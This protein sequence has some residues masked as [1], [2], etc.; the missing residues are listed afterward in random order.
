M[1]DDKT[2]WKELDS[3]LNSKEVGSYRY[4]RAGRA[5]W[6]WACVASENLISH[7]MAWTETRAI[8][9]AQRAPRQYR[10]EIARAIMLERRARNATIAAWDR[11]VARTAAHKLT[12]P[13]RGEAPGGRSPNW[14][15]DPIMQQHEEDTW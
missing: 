11:R 10:E 2:I 5:R 13:P 7:G 1:S 9:Q 3:H 4:V 15:D 8:R 6:L 12:P 14:L